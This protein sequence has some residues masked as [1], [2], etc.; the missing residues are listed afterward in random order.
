MDIKDETD[1]GV[2]NTYT[3]AKTRVYCRSNKV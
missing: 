1:L 2:I 3:G